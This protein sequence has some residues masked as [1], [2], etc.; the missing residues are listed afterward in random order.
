MVPIPGLLLIYCFH[1]RPQDEVQGWPNKS[2][3]GFAD[4]IDNRFQYDCQYGKN[5]S[6]NSP[7]AR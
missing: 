3:V 2:Y 6:L 7:S 4:Y 5:I 1:W